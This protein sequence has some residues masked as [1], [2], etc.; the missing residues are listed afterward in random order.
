MLKVVVAVLFI[1]HLTICEINSNDIDLTSQN[2]LDN[3]D[4]K[5]FSVSENITNYSIFHQDY[6]PKP[7]PSGQLWYFNKCR[8]A[9]P[10]K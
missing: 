9:R 2:S 10:G 6:I 7:C 8:N 5:S 1:T 3:F 4:E